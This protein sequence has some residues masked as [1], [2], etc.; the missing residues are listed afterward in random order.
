MSYNLKTNLYL[1]N[2][3]LTSEWNREIKTSIGKKKNKPSLFLAIFRTFYLQVSPIVLYKMIIEYLMRFTQPILIGFIVQYL[4]TKSITFNQAVL[5]GLGI[6]LTS[7]MHTYA[8]HHGFVQLSRIGNNIRSALSIMIYEKLLRLSTCS[9]SEI[10]FGHVVTLLA[11]DLNQIEDFLWLFP[12]LIFAPIGVVITAVIS[13]NYLKIS[14]A[15]GFIIMFLLILFQALMS[16]IISKINTK[17]IK[18]TDERV[19]IMGEIIGTMKLIKLYCWEKAFS[20]K[21]DQIRKDEINTMKKNYLIEGVN[22]SLYFV[23]SKVMMFA[24]LVT[25]VLN[26]NQLDE[27]TVFVMMSL[28]N[29]VRVPI[30]D[31]FP[32]AVGVTAQVLV[33][34]TRIEKYLLMKEIDSI[35]FTSSSLQEEKEEVKIDLVH[36]SAKWKNNMEKNTIEN[37]NLTIKSGT[38]VTIIGPIGS[39]KSTLLMALLKE[40]KCTSGSIT[41]D[42]KISYAAQDAW[43]F[44]GTVREN[45]IM[46]NNFNEYRFSNVIKVCGLTRDLSLFN[47]SDMSLV[48]EK[49]Y[50]LSGGQRAR[51]SLARAI[52]NYADIYLLD[53]PLSAVDPKV[54]K[55]IFEECI[56]S[57]LKGKTIVLVTHQLQFIRKADTVVIIENGLIKSQG[58]YNQLINQGIDFLSIF[59]KNNSNN[60]EVNKG[61][62]G[63]IN[64]ISS[65][66]SDFDEIIESYGEIKP[67]EETVAHGR[68]SGQVYSQYFKAGG[69]L[70]TFTIV[71]IASFMSQGLTIFSDLWLSAW[72]SI[73]SSEM[74]IN[75]TDL[76]KEA[77]GSSAVSSSTEINLIIYTIMIILL[78]VSSF[79]RF[80]SNYLFCLQ[81]SIKIHDLAFTKI[82]RTPNSFF[83]CNPLGRILN[84]FSRDIAMIDLMIPHN[85]VELNIGLLE[86]LSI[87]IICIMTSIWL[88]IPLTFILI[89]SI[90]CREYFI[91]TS[92]CLFRLDAL[93]K[94]PIYSHVVSSF[95][96]II[97]LRAFNL[98]IA[99][100]EQFVNYV[101]DS[102][103]CRFNVLYSSRLFGCLLDLLINIFVCSVCIIILSMP[104]GTIVGSDAGLI[105]SS[106]LYLAGRLQYTVRV[107]AEFENNMVS[108]ERII[109]YSKLSSEAPAEIKETSP[110]NEWPE[111]GEIEFK[112]VLL[113]YSTSLPPV[114]KNINF[115]INSCE[116]VGIVGRTGAGKSSLI[117]SLFRLVELTKGS[118]FIDSVDISKIGLDQLRQKLSIVPQDPSLFSGTVRM[119]LDPFNQYSDDKIWSALTKAKMNKAIMSMNGG[120]NAKISKGGCNLSVGQRQLLCLA[121]ALLKDNRIWI[122]DEA[123]ANVDHE[124]D[125][126][127]QETIRREFTNC[128]VLTVAHR[129][130]TVIEMDRIMVLSEG[131][132]VEFDSPH[133]LM[134]DVNGY[135]T[136]MVKQTGKQLENILK[137][138]A[139]KSYK[140]KMTSN[141]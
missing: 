14:F 123:T 83:E 60:R 37:I 33:A 36:Y 114:L 47:N 122:L 70:I 103:A 11:N 91:R 112:N 69:N 100:Q 55:Q 52:Y 9:L 25:F 139:E 12:Y 135:F 137:D 116:K 10:D 113:K 35:E 57:F 13:Y 24:T 138:A 76:A 97:S 81:C 109:E 129:L 30:T 136:S 110:N 118:I 105:L 45:I 61:H 22:H 133:L 28:Y 16:K 1:V 85:M 40:I 5:S 87:F 19:T 98:Q 132:V 8:S 95:N 62:S 67:E 23:I 6:I 31:N 17:V 78:L 42:G 65:H 2:F 94:S 20:K 15:S 4:T 115:K 75:S 126:I 92:R 82:I 140:Q 117:S 128:T 90:P 46:N 104:H 38:L 127:I 124:T 59:E 121:R 93:S 63:S 44:N 74:K 56:C 3:Y 101:K 58:N 102:V 119:N 7:F 108:T 66:G 27:V 68:V 43:C 48:G 71:I 80:W 89:I 21:V 34:F 18:I 99:Y 141:S 134:K 107:T 86:S 130:N 106:C 49:G 84:R 29:S 53:D 72:S 39:G 51:I 79:I 32:W 125:S 41:V 50:T 64:S 77:I 54:A 111:T 26:G 88:L 96:G 131:N 73:G 120:L